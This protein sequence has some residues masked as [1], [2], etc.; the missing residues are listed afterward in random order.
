MTKSALKK[1]GLLGV[2]FALALGLAAVPMAGA[3][4]LGDTKPCYK[5]VLVPT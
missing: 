3:L 2:P 1:A 4:Q 5:L